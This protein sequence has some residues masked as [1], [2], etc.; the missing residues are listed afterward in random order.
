M[1]FLKFEVGDLV[2]IERGRAYPTGEGGK[3]E[4]TEKPGVVIAVRGG[5]HPYRVRYEQKTRPPQ[6]T[7]AW[8]GSLRPRE[9]LKVFDLDETGDR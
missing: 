2:W 5:K 8:P 3:W 1:E 6:E 9:E 7:W 4:A